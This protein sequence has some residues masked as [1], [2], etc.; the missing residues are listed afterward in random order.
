MICER[1][2]NSDKCIDLTGG[3]SAPGPVDIYYTEF[4]V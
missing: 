4:I 1:S 2:K 3:S